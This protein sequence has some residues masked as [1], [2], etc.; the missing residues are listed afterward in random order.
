MNKRIL[1]ADDSGTARRALRALLK[2]R[3]DWQLCA[4]AVDGLDAVAK[5]KSMVPDVAVLDL[6]MGGLNGVQAASQIRSSC[7]TTAVLTISLYDARPLF[8]K[9]QTAGVRGFVSKSNLVAELL[10][11]IDAVLGGQSWFPTPPDA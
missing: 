6:A 3:E 2:R 9:L 4:E 1:L 5:A 8:S 10:P 11:A 7:P